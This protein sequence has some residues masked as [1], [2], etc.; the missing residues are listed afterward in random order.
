MVKAVKLM[1]VGSKGDDVVMV[2]V[3]MVIVMMMATRL[4]M[5]V[6]TVVMMVTMP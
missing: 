3:K 2:R 5:L 4:E 1:T 6:T